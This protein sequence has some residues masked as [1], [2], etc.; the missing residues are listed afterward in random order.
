MCL[1]VINVRPVYRVIVIIPLHIGQKDKCAIAIRYKPCKGLQSPFPDWEYQVNRALLAKL[2]HSEKGIWASVSFSGSENIYIF[3]P[4][5]YN[6]FPSFFTS[7]ERRKTPLF[8]WIFQNTFQSP[9]P[10][11][12]C[13]N[14]RL[15][16]PPPHLAHLPPSL[17][18][19]SSFV[20]LSLCFSEKPNKPAIKL[21]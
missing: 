3:S 2:K 16:L 18:S 20:S 1:Y 21:S 9:S 10:P 13:N 6:I 7:R 14:L 11:T 19:L 5:I 12:P 4:Q 8:K 17:F 15:Y